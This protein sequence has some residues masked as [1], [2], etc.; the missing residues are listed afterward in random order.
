MKKE[1]VILIILYLSSDLDV[2]VE[3][4]IDFNHCFI[5]SH[6]ARSLAEHGKCTERKPTSIYDLFYIFFAFVQV[7]L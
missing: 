5:R 7:F 6:Y 4:R 2:D 1:I 3:L